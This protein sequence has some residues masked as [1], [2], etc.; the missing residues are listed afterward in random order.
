M[1]KQLIS[2]AEVTDRTNVSENGSFVARIFALGGSEMTVMYTSPYASNGEGAFIAVP[3]VGVEVIVIRP[4][5]SDSWYYMGSTFSPEPRQTTGDGIPVAQTS[6]FSRPPSTG[7]PESNRGRPGSPRVTGIEGEGLVIAN[8]YAPGTSRSKHLALGQYEDAGITMSPR[9]IKHLDETPTPDSRGAI[10]KYTTLKSPANKSISLNDSP[11]IDSIVFDS[12]NGSIMK[13]TSTPG[14]DTMAGAGM[15]VPDRAFLVDTQGPQRLVSHSQTDVV[16]A[17]DGRELQ[18]LNFANDVEWGDDVNQGSVNIQSKWRDV[19]VLT[20]GGA[21]A[22]RIFIQCLD[23]EGKNTGQVI[24]IETKGTDG[25]IIIKTVGDI[26]LN[27]EGG[28]LNINADEEIRMK[29]GKFSLDCNS[30]E[31]K[32][33]G[34]IN[35]D[36]SEIHLAGGGANPTPVETPSE[37]SIYQPKGITTY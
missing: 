21:G 12:G 16:V 25:S 29:T 7:T 34:V 9:Q 26:T 28:S 5:C 8:D 3:E 15:G 31:V 30:I 18:L 19:N 11:A 35:M 36:G 6:P 27:A 20:L 4:S 1:A 14:G 37:E 17:K 10:N 13:L 32:S 33:E 23:P 24:Q 2:L 22:G